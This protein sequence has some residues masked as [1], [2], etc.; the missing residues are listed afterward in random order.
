MGPAIATMPP[1][2]PPQRLGRITTYAPRQRR[3][4]PS[5][6][7]ATVAL[8]CPAPPISLNEASAADLACLPGIGPGLAARIV[9]WRTSHGRF[10]EVKDLEQVP[11]IG[12]VRV[13]RLLPYVRAP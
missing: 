6:A 11:G 4:K 3:A 13:Q 5:S 8:A 9:T 7:P 10:T 12:G 1:P 2:P